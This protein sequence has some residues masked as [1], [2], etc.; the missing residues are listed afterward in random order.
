[1]N[2][3]TPAAPRRL[4]V[5][6]KTAKRRTQS[7]NRWLERQLNDPYVIRSKADGYRSRAAYKLIEIDDK[8]KLLSPGNRVVD[9]G[10][11][12]GGWLQVAVARVGSKEGAPRVVG[13]DYLDVDPVPGTVILKKDFLDADA[14]DALHAALGG[15]AVDVVL[16]DMAAPATGHKKTDQL[17]ITYLCEIAIDFA[18][19]TLRP[20]GHFVAKVLR[21]GTETQLLAEL[22]RDFA[23]V[24]HVKPPASRS[25]S[26]ELYVLGKNF[27]GRV[28]EA[29]AETDDGE[30]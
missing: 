7:S 19:K 1:M 15:H 4:K 21:G 22:K 11:A 26:A 27:R 20:G 8:Y 30:A 12:P 9:L 13:I 24:A 18:R 23:I 28:A 25:D 3:E 29:A 6:V 16:S 5:K 10:C 17:K 2:D 14:P